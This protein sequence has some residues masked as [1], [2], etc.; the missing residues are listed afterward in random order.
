MEHMHITLEVFGVGSA[1]GNYERHFI[2]VKTD[3]RFYLRCFRCIVGGGGA[4]GGLTKVISEVGV[5]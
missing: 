1:C 4:N 3:H 5:E 2:I